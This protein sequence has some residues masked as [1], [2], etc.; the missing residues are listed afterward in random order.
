[1]NP[2]KH[3]LEIGMP[4]KALSWK[5]PYGTLMLHGKIETR[6]WDTNY[7][8]LVLI[9]TSKQPYSLDKVLSISGRIQMDRILT[10]FQRNPQHTPFGYAIAIG[11]LI[12]S[13]DMNVTD[14]DKCFVQWWPDL[15]CHVYIDVTPIVPFPWKGSQGWRTVSKSIINQIK[16]IE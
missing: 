1:M 10:L 5:E 9:C 4:L 13:R 12:D 7:R 15:Y 3:D 6:N 2:V 11:R 8:G 16:F 14:E